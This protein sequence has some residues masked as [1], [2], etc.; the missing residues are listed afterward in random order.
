MSQLKHKVRGKASADFFE[1]Q[2]EHADFGA[3]QA[4]RAITEAVAPTLRSCVKYRAKL[5]N[6]SITSITDLVIYLL[7][8]TPRTDRKKGTRLITNCIYEDL[9][10]VELQRRGGIL[11]IRCLTC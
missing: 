2:N 9:I 11:W 1:L 10:V 3:R 5:E 7:R 6:V 8:C 4:S